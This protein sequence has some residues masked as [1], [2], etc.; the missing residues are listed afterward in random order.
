MGARSLPQGP[1]TITVEALDMFG[2]TAKAQ[3]EVVRTDVRSLPEQATRLNFDVG[4]SGLTR[5]VE[6]SVEAPGTGFPVT[7][8]VHLSWQFRGKAGWKT[9]HRASR[10]AGRPFSYEQRLAR[11]GRWRVVVE[12]L[13]D[14]PF[15]GSTA[16]SDLL[17]A[18]A[19]RVRG[20]RA[21]AAIRHRTASRHAG[22]RVLQLRRVRRA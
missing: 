7:G 3:V 17:E 15:A 12:Y 14:A 21:R 19:A 10:P 1:V 6:G 11:P 4:G 16:T 5:T 22:R 8:R 18:R 20:H 9:L 2:N 13:G